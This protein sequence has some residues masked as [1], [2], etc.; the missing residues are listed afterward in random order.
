MSIEMEYNTSQ[1]SGLLSDFVKQ[2]WA[3]DA[4]H[5]NGNEHIQR[6]V[7]NGL[8]DLTFYIGDRPV[9]LDN[10]RSYSENTLISGQLKDYYDIKVHGSFT[11]FSVIFQPY[12]LSAFFDIPVTEFFNLNVPLRYILKG[13]IDELET[14]LYEA[15]SFEERI[16]VIE[17]FLFRRLKGSKQKFNF[18][19]LKSSIGLIN[20]H[21]GIVSVDFLA[22]E[23][24][25]SRK[26]YE[27]IFCSIIGTSPKQFLKIVR[28]QSALHQKAVSPGLNLTELTYSSGYYDQSHMTNEFHK[29]TGMSPS[30]YFSDCDPYSDYFQ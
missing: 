17:R 10:D 29:L 26:Q 3:M 28:F 18:D 21:K 24:C 15:K 19:R 6:I 4:V 2:Y 16:I 27:R 7:P 5:H 30:Q 25:L 23:A 14:S 12:G 9:P 20:K 1:P 22:S 11:L 8:Q 13:V